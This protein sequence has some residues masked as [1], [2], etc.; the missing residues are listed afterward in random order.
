MYL[1]SDSADYQKNPFIIDGWLFI[2][3]ANSRVVTLDGN[4][5]KEYRTFEPSNAHESLADGG[6]QRLMN[7]YDDEAGSILTM[8]GH[9]FYSLNAKSGDLITSILG[10]FFNI[11]KFKENNKFLPFI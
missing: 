2:T 11:Y 8:K 4:A 3:T 10:K 9:R 1:K 7:W 6:Q 5:G